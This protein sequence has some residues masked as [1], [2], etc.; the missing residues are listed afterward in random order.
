M[1]V[2]IIIGFVLLAM[3]LL[4]VRVLLKKDG[5]FSSQHISQSRAMRERGIDCVNTQDWK[6]RQQ[7]PKRLDVNKL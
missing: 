5:R 2:L 1:K 3:V 4:S 6:D 7:D